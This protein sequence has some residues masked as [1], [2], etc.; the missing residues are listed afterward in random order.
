MRQAVASAIGPAPGS[1]RVAG[2]NPEGSSCCWGVDISYGGLG[3]AMNGPPTR[4][5][6]AGGRTAEF[7]AVAFDAFATSTLDR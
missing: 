2:V 6:A 7:K 3:F 4:P 1:V 5:A